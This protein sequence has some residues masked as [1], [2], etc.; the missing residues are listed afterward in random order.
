MNFSIRLTLHIKW[1]NVFFNISI[2]L[3]AISYAGIIYWFIASVNHLW[4]PWH[5]GLISM[6]SCVLMS[7]VC[8][9]AAG[10]K[11]LTFKK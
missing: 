9:I 6:E 5:L 2:S 3:L 8:V 10:E 4:K 11:Y 1:R 7:T